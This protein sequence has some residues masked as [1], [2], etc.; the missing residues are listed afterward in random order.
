MTAESVLLIAAL[1]L[2]GIGMGFVYLMLGLMVLAIKLLAWLAGQDEAVIVTQVAPPCTAGA[3]TPATLAA[4]GA[5]IHHYQTNSSAA[6][7]TTETH[8]EERR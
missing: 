1:K 7:A 3:V 2:M 5:A 4:I 6:T 8:R